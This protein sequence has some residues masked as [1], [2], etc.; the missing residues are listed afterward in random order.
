[1]KNLSIELNVYK[2]ISI[3]LLILSLAQYTFASEY[4]ANIS[5]SGDAITQYDFERISIP[6]TIKNSGS[7]Q[8]DSSVAKG[9]VFITYH[10][11]SDS[12]KTILKWDNPRTSF[13]KKIL[14]EE[15]S[16]VNL[17]L[18]ALSVGRY[19]VRIDLVA[20]GVTWFKDQGS[21]ELD[22]I[23]DIVESK[24]TIAKPKVELEKYNSELIW[25]VSKEQ[26]IN[27]CA[28]LANK[29]IKS[30][31]R[32]FTFE[33]TPVWG[34]TAGAGYPQIWIRDSATIM[35]ISRQTISGP[36][37]TSWIK[38][39]LSIQEKSG[40]LQDWIGDDDKFDKNTVESDQESSLIIGAYEISKTIGYDWL[41]KDVNSRSILLRLHDAL[42][43]LFIQRIDRSTGLIKSGHTADWGDVS[44]EFSDQRAI[45]LDSNSSEVLGIYTN[46]L[47]YG[48]AT[49]LSYLFEQSGMNEKSLYWKGES[50]KLAKNIQHFLW[51]KDKGFYRTHKH[52]NFPDH[53][54]FDE[55]NIFPMGGNAVAIEMGVTNSNQTQS[56]I[57]QALLRQKLFNFSTI[58]GALLPPYPKD[59]FKNPILNDY[60]EYQ[61][62]GQW[63]WFGGRL[64]LQMFHNDHPESLNKLREICTKSFLNK[65]FYEWNTMDG[66]GRG[67]SHY[68]GSAAV[69][70]RAIIEGLFGIAWDY[71][72]IRIKPRL[73]LDSGYIYLPRVA[74]S[75]F[76]SYEL[77]IYS[78]TTD[79]IIVKI[80][81]G[82]NTKY[83]KTLML[84][85]QYNEYKYDGIIKNGNT[86]QKKAINGF[87][88]IDL[89][90]GRNEILVKYLKFK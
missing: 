48:A 69:V 19:I 74:T 12:N 25:Y 80:S 41:L 57:H 33:N 72:S 13:Q 76:V 15:V 45:D 83:K 78:K 40:E 43:F 68:T 61:N 29:V 47:A 37:L 27:Y 64:V 28:L 42:N 90:S 24:R 34:H 86:L 5:Y 81:M 7:K 31:F 8:W 55:D 77:E 32:K 17:R 52:I 84:P 75:E 62:G 65:G 56:I 1:M 89:G 23:V 70:S 18:P 6:L 60:F 26:E 88:E 66:E 85:K 3:L 51:Q 21:K 67:S 63:D 58:S 2:T 87:V 30:N 16:L 49:K 71:D 54:N 79:K 39:H 73:I 20:E 9:P 22:V 59:F 38:A 82:S 44:N 53:T 36:A 4:N 14:P 50:E 46:A 35:P 11:L 10:L